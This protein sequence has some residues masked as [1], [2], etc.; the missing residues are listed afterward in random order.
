MDY[1]ICNGRYDAWV[2][3]LSRQ[4]IY[5]FKDM[6]TQA[7]FSH[8]TFV[9]DIP[10]SY[11]CIGD[12]IVA[13]ESGYIPI[14][15]I[16]KTTKASAAN[17]G[18][19]FWTDG[20]A[21]DDTIHVNVKID[22]KLFPGAMNDFIAE[23]K[24]VLRHELEHVAQFNLTDKAQ[25]ERFNCVPFH[26][27]LTLRHEVPAFV[28]GLHKK[29]KTLKQPLSEVFEDFFSTYID[30]FQCNLEIDNVRTA[31]TEYAIQKIRNFH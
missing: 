29:A 4:Y 24:D 13:T 19:A 21:D 1:I 23:I 26:K 28:M 16:F 14:D 15:I 17:I 6:L 18:S 2:T 10:S 12:E 25:I 5:Q 11:Q 27:Y 31:W 7:K 3:T 20:S 22:P 9:A 8:V 30:S